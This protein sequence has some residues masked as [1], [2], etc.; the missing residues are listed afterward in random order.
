MNI[1]AG[2]VG[3]P[4]VGKSTLF[5]ALTKAGV[6][7]EN[8]PF[9]TIDP[10]VAIT[11]VPDERLEKMA[12]LYRSKKIVPADSMFVDI[13]GLVKGAAQGEG[14]GNQFLSHIREVNLIIHVLRCFEDPNVIHTS[15]TIDPLSDLE[16]I[17]QELML[18]DV[19]SIQKR[20]E[21][22]ESLI[23]SS[24]QKPAERKQLEAEQVFINEILAAINQFDSVKIKNLVKNSLITTI[25][26]LSSKNFIMVANVGEESVD[27][28]RWLNNQHYQALVKQFGSEKVIPLC[29]KLE[30]DLSELEPD[31]AKQLIQELGVH[32]S[33]LEHIIKTTYHELGLITFFTC[34]PQE[35]HAWP[36]VRGTTIK[37]A[38]GEIHSDF[39]RG[40]ICAEI[41]NY[42]DVITYGSEQKLKELGKVRTEGAT[43]VVQ[44]GDI[45]LIRFN[46]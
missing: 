43:Y 26:L 37:Q 23:K 14:L 40:F 4:N 18:K 46:V 33:S 24:K 7:A 9:C 25:P 36:I 15:S 13:A 11:H 19:E 5:N 29:V 44:D 6:P 34:G 10:H 2:L 3:L 21:K 28:D 12:I 41:Y 1:K 20:L 17:Q 8:Y 38:A 30:Q 31:Q 42:T 16:I 35:S 32:E 45:V 22:L 27:H 39:E